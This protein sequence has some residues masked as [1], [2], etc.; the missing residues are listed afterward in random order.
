MLQT[1]SSWASSSLSASIA[2]T[3]SYVASAS[4]Y[5]PDNP[6]AVSA[7][8]VSS[9]VYVKNADT[10]SYVTSASY[11]P[12]FPAAVPS[13]SWVSASA[14]I[15][16]AQTASYVTSS[17]IVGIITA[18]SSSWSSQS[19][20]SS[21][22]TTSSF[23]QTASFVTTSSFASS[24]PQNISVNSLTASFISA[25]QITASNITASGN[26]IVAAGGG[27]S[28][29]TTQ[30]GVSILNGSIAISNYGQGTV[31][32]CLQLV[33]G[34]N[35]NVG[36]GE[37]IDFCGAN[38]AS[39]K[40]NISSLRT[41]FGSG[42]SYKMQ[43]STRA[44]GVTSPTLT[45]LDVGNVGIGT[46]APVN[47]LD[48]VGN[49]SCGV[50]TASTAIIPTIG[51]N[52]V[53]ADL[54]PSTSLIMASNAFSGST[55]N[56]SGSNLILAGGIGKNY[57]IISSGSLLSGSTITVTVNGTVTT[58]IGS[59]SN[60]FAV[61]SSN[62]YT[63][64]SMS[65]VI[66]TISGVTSSFSASLTTP[67]LPGYVF[68]IPS[69]GTYALTLATNAGATT[70]SVTS[71]KAGNVGIGINNPLT[72]LD[73]LGTISMRAGNGI[74][75]ISSDGA[76]TLLLNSSTGN[77]ANVYGELAPSSNGQSLGD[78]AR[79][80][81]GFFTNVNASGNISCS[82]ITASL[83]FGTSSFST[84]AASMSSVPV[85]ATS[86]SWVSAS[87]YIT[88]AD[89]ASYF[90]T[91]SVTSAS[92]AY[93][94]SYSATSSITLTASYVNTTI[95]NV[96]SASWAS[97]SVSASAASTASYV[98]NLYPQVLQITVLS[99]SWISASVFITTAQ[100]A[101]YVAGNVASASYSS[102][103]SYVDG[104]ITSASYAN[105]ASYVTGNVTSADFAV[106][107][108]NTLYS[109]SYAL[110]S[111]YSLGGASSTPLS[112]IPTY[113]I[114]ASFSPSSSISQG[115]LIFWINPNSASYMDTCGQYQATSNGN[116][117]K[118]MN[119][120]SGLNS[121]VSV[122]IGAAGY[123]KFIYLTGVGQNNNKCAVWVENFLGVT[124]AA[125]ATTPT[126]PLWLFAVLK[127]P[128][129]S[130]S[131]GIFDGNGSSNRFFC[132]AGTSP[133]IYSGASLSGAIT[134]SL[135]GSIQSKWF[136]QSFKNTSG[137]ANSYVKTNGT[138]SIFGSCGTQTINGYNFGSDN[139]GNGGGSSIAEMLLYSNITDADA[140]NIETYLKSK[141]ELFY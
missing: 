126:Y 50:I 102:T 34:G 59:G 107:A 110:T 121:N 63:A 47:K 4:Y 141:H 70:A 84:T 25:S 100:T 98:P 139:G 14:F 36:T 133:Q 103:A 26:I 58:L 49:I 53:T 40:I 5:P 6:N 73:V 124:C 135:T 82:V 65:S 35:N 10:A 48:V 83:F 123:N 19:L 120:L 132:A 64:L 55:V 42:D 136:L 94:A 99:A 116:P 96:A 33:N 71:G 75:G 57:F 30:N 69:V 92:Y 129:G 78:T 128:S 61:S 86:A 72:A 56:T 13:A 101:S 17:N 117:I 130:T 3:A 46:I 11:Y 62:Y 97:S 38:S 51:G 32:S 37:S 108:G 2:D 127:I 27:S 134:G 44:S 90:I 125:V 111:S 23:S 115:Q 24:I 74:A 79:R 137:G 8:W 18:F 7:S 67:L 109:S 28:T 68:V 85:T 52:T 89:T 93:T 80:W 105:T 31:Q 16:T 113:G 76:G 131:V 39:T 66:N 112:Y 138:Q 12:V 104:N 106:I 95:S 114:T 140:V 77:G 41:S 20:S 87:V 29:S 81:S 60:S 43:F 15:T 1:S 54:P 88:A 21:F 118:H 91:S 22:S 119:D 122:P 45:L 9:S